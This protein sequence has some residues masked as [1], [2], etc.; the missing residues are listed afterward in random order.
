MLAADF[1]EVMV[2]YVGEVGDKMTLQ[3]SPL[4][5]KL[6]KTEFIVVGSENVM[7]ML[8][9][10]EPDEEPTAPGNERRL[11][12][13]SAPIQ[14]WHKSSP[15]L[16]DSS[17]APADKTSGGEDLEESPD[18]NDADQEEGDGKCLVPFREGSPLPISG[19]NGEIIK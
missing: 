14:S 19:F 10:L 11:L 8:K 4:I 9:S 6:M 15:S 17:Y 5:E 2:L 16:A 18:G 13:K 7:S 1:H 3:I 12:R